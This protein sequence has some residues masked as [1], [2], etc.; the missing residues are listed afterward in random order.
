MEFGLFSNQVPPR[1]NRTSG[2]EEWELKYKQNLVRVFWAT[3]Q[4]KDLFDSPLDGM[5]IKLSTVPI[6]NYLLSKRGE[7]VLGHLYFELYLK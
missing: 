2:D 1:G 7:W 6:K 4:D 3:K 5:K